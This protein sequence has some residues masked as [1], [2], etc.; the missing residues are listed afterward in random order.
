MALLRNILT[1]FALVCLGLDEDGLVME[2]DLE[3][4]FCIYRGVFIQS[5]LFEWNPPSAVSY[6]IRVK[7]CE[8]KHP[9]DKADLFKF[10]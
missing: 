7:T 10:L 4:S 1:G 2:H 3:E 6:H 8:E 5:V 9:L